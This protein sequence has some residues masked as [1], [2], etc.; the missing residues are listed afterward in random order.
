MGPYGKEPLKVS[1][2]PAL[3]RGHRHCGSGDIMVLD[4]H[5][6]LQ[7]HKN[8]GSSDFKDKSPLS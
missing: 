6:I 7:D 4:C 2:H 3:F 1:H 5:V 8:K